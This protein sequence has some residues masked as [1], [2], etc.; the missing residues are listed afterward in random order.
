[1]RQDI[2][3]EQ[4]TDPVVRGGAIVAFT[5]S[6]TG[7]DP[8]TVA[9]VANTIASIYLTENIRVREQEASGT[10]S[11][12]RKQL[13]EV[14]D[15]LEGQEA[16]VSV[17]KRRYIG[18]NPKNMDANLAVLE[19]LTAQLRS[20]QRQP[21]SRV[22]ATRGARVASWRE[23]R[24][25]F[26]SL[27]STESSRRIRVVVRLARLHHELVELQTR[28]SDK[29]PDV[30]RLKGEIAALEAQAQGSPVTGPGTERRGERSQPVRLQA[31]AGHCR[32]GGGDRG[33]SGR[34]GA[35]ARGFRHVP[36]PGGEH[37]APGAGVPGTVSRL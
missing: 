37:A 9:A 27:E 7:R 19:R 11:F 36:A 18:E 21:E 35:A 5:V 32:D 3:I 23:A 10:A 17:F 31:S 33:A 8:A 25:P 13:E 20:E 34:G 30:L 16:R 15:R 26:R 29:Y 1:M 6:Y 12:L 22:G 4:R 14:K 28:F 2:K 24:E